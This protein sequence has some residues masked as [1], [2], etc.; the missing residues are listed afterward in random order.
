VSRYQP[1][2]DECRLLHSETRDWIAAYRASAEKGDR[3]AQGHMAMDGINT[4]R[5]ETRTR[6]GR[7]VAA[8]VAADERD[9][10]ALRSVIGD[11]LE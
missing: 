4:A 11:P 6:L 3:L 2:L 5:F 7:L 8:V 1:L 9:P 10:D